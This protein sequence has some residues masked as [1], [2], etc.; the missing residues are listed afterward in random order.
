MESKFV[1]YNK[2]FGGWSNLN[3][4]SLIIDED[5][6]LLLFNNKLILS[7]NKDYVDFLKIL[8]DVLKPFNIIILEQ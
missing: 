1:I 8:N 6:I 7:L 5:I 2:Y 3:N 4:T